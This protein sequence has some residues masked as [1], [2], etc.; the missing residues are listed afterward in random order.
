MTVTNDW[1]NV[2][3][4][5][6]KK[7]KINSF[8]FEFESVVI[9][10]LSKGY[11]TSKSIFISH[12]DLELDTDYYCSA[13]KI[14]NFRNGMD[15]FIV[16]NFRKLTKDEITSLIAQM[17]QTLEVCPHVGNKIG[18]SLALANQTLLLFNFLNNKLINSYGIKMRKSEIEEAQDYLKTIVRNSSFFRLLQENR[19]SVK[20]QDFV[21]DFLKQNSEVSLTESFY[22]YAFNIAC[23]EDKK[24]SFLFKDADG[25]A[26]R[27]NVKNDSEIRI[28][29][30]IESFF[31][32]ELKNNR[33]ALS[34][35]VIEDGLFSNKWI[36]NN[37]GYID[38]NDNL[39]SKQSY[40]NMLNKMINADK[41]RCYNIRNKQYI[42][43]IDVISFLKKSTPLYFY[44]KDMDVTENR[45]I[46][47]LKR[48]KDDNNQTHLLNKK[49]NSKDINTYIS[50]YEQLNSLVLSPDQKSALL[51]MFN[52]KLICINGGAGT[53][54]TKLLDAFIFIY[55]KLN[56][57]N[58]NI[59]FSKNSKL[60]SEMQ[61]KAESRNNH[62]TKSRACALPV[63]LTAPTGKA[64]LHLE[65]ITG[66]NAFTIHK[67][68]GIKNIVDNSKAVFLDTEFL[69][70]DEASML[71]TSLFL[72]ILNHLS[73]DT[74][75]ILVGDSNQLPPV[76][77][78]MPFADLIAAKSFPVINL[79]SNF[80]QKDRLS[81]LQADNDL[82]K[83]VLPEMSVNNLEAPVSMFNAN[84][85][86]T[87]LKKT[88]E[89]V[90]LLNERH[91]FGKTFVLTQTH[92]GFLGTFLLNQNIQRLVN[93]NYVGSDKKQYFIGDKVLQL[94]NEY[95]NVSDVMN[96]EIGV[97]KDVFE[98]KYGKQLL[99][100]N[101][102]NRIFEYE[103]DQLD[104]LDLAYALTIH[105]AQGS[106]ADIVVFPISDSRYMT[107]E[108]IY[109]A[110]TRAKKRLVFIGSKKLLKNALSRHSNIL[111]PAFDAKL[112]LV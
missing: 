32:S 112:S 45:I 64:A 41:I 36:Q 1:C 62:L 15:G 38:G 76:N 39:L 21:S 27:L 11:V 106:E 99:K 31:R 6:V 51:T 67:V 80:R 65:E 44:L 86:S 111:N 95:H 19:F 81:L 87:A 18:Q 59:L 98:D 30:I 22:K 71:D 61:L 78:G 91:L 63:T 48:R 4:H 46:T 52:S 20:N 17:E 24:K 92:N 107:R 33:F 79:K 23:R 105:K 9:G 13:D 94:K 7:T 109:T 102:H 75:I 55:K 101:F 57:L 49:Y 47:F 88:L 69:I 34:P 2:Y 16:K 83:G 85:K 97:V 100:V 35:E 43:S 70:I 68:F 72:R 93:S 73:F 104:K 3:F 53:G 40:I 84:K 12:K 110:A 54:K 28:K 5:P 103:P 10:N 25:I 26:C 74:K 42:H 108:M 56:S 90:A 14:P 82:L 89:I 58:P 50:A 66:E 37:S 29:Y 60:K 8:Y 77:A 96:G